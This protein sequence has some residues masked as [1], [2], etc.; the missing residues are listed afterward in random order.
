MEQGEVGDIFQPKHWPVGT[1]TKSSSWHVTIDDSSMGRRGSNHKVVFRH[2]V[3]EGNW[4][5]I[6]DG[7]FEASG[8]EP[9][10]LQPF[11]VSF[12]MGNNNAHV[13]GEKNLMTMKYSFFINNREQIPFTCQTSSAFNEIIPT[14][15][16]IPSRV[17]RLQEQKYAIYY[18]ISV[19][20][21]DGSTVSVNRRYSEFHML[22][23]ALRG[24][25]DG[26]L[27]S[28]LPELPGK[29]FNPFVNQMSEE[30]LDRRQ[31]RLQSYLQ[32][33]LGNSKAVYYTEFLCFLGLDPITGYPIT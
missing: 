11:T 8:Y 17:A 4:V 29:V 21:P 2:S 10:A 33:L 1:T 9:G 28:S 13:A 32:T 22:D 20:M 25:L 3:L 24:Q 5:L 14:T 18:Q 30:F 16:S 15:L 19:Q 31:H 12:K 27:L 26:H 23:R 7:R 6:V